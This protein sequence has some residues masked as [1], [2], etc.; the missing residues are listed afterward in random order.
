MKWPVVTVE[1]VK[2]EEAEEEAERCPSRDEPHAR[3]VTTAA[4][5]GALVLLV[6]VSA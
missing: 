6:V 3:P 1:E 5:S 4:H 2:G